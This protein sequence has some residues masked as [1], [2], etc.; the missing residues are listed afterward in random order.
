MSQWLDDTDRDSLI[1]TLGELMSAVSEDCYCAGW[2]DGTE[3][4][5][6]ALCMLV[7]KTKRPHSWGMGQ[8][9]TGMAAVLLTL[10]D[11]LG[12][13][14]TLGDGA[15]KYEPFDPWPTP[16]SSLDQIDRKVEIRAIRPTK[17]SSVPGASGMPPAGQEPRR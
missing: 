7:A 17:E 9:D 4:V 11:K 5:V 10:A 6:P 13:W 12:H 16:Q 14:V 3:H 8:L 2:L 1:R 15:T